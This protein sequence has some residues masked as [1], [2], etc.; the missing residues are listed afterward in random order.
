MSFDPYELDRSY[1]PAGQV[2]TIGQYTAKTFLWMVLGLLV[3]FGIAVV[4][5][6]TNATLYALVYIPYCHLIVLIAT[7]V[8]SVTMSAR[9][10]K[11]AVATARIMFLTFSALF[12]FTMSIYLYIFEFGSLIFVFLAT[13][14][15]FGALAAYGYLTKAD[16]S[17]LR[18]ILFS[19]LLFLIL[20][21]VISMFIPG[22]QMLDRIACIIGIAI[23]L[24]YTAYDTQRIKAYYSYYAGYPDMLEKASVFSALQLYLDFINLFLYLLRFLG[25]ARRN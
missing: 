23:F 8:L 5:W 17:N 7:L 13:A 11:M 19:G 12:G 16:L 2:E 20:F 4:C 15:Y 18:P 9:I 1:T 10:E 6:A 14:V 3:T 22:L 24:G 25:K 21:G